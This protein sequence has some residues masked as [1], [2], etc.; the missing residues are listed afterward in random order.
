[1]PME[2][3]FDAIAMVRAIRE[4]HQEAL[5]DAS[6][7]ER[8]QFYKEQARALQERFKGMQADFERDPDREL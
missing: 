4:A 8:V 5:K 1:M 6:P 3:D 7:E 2:K